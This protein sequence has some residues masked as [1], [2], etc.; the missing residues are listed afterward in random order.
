MTADAYGFSVYGWMYL[1]A[2]LGLPWGAELATFAAIYSVSHHG[3]GLYQAAQ[4]QMAE[5]LGLSRR[6]VARALKCLESK[7]YIYRTT[8]RRQGHGGRATPCWMVCQPAVDG[9]VEAVRYITME[10]AEDAAGRARR[11]PG[12]VENRPDKD[13][14]KSV[15]NTNGTDNV[16]DRHIAMRQSGTLQCDDVSAEAA[17][18]RQHDTLQCDDL[19]NETTCHIAKNGPPPADTTSFQHPSYLYL[20]HYLTDK[21][22]DTSLEGCAAE[23]GR[24]AT[25]A[26]RA[27]F[28]EL[29][30]ASPLGVPPTRLREAWTAYL[31][32]L[33]AIAPIGGEARHVL[34]AMRD[35]VSYHRHMRSK[36]GAYKVAHLD[37]WLR[38]RP[39]GGGRANKWIL[40]AIDHDCASGRCAAGVRG[41]RRR[42]AADVEVFRPNAGA[43]WFAKGDGLPPGGS[44]VRVD[45][46][47][48]DIG[49]T[50]EEAASAARRM[51]AAEAP[52]GGPD[53][54]R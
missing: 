16:P 2:G 40:H 21:D 32:V 17:P 43:H 18:M 10:P 28:G 30:S 36:T 37:G 33:D 47:P 51:V 24:A 11:S 38:Q 8:V 20:Y 54:P 27:A 7:G 41:P 34:S 45:G 3:Q 1:D 12:D 29:C 44:M 48:L 15:E 35:Y 42:Q 39:K 25:E 23:G 13:V 14:E 19:A 5:A 46:L 49:A 4:D 9:A 22:R 26:E 52:G 50:Q 6:S 31:E 53:G